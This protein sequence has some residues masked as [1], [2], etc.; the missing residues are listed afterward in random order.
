MYTKT[1]QT[2]DTYI[3][4]TAHELSKQHRVKVA[5]SDGLEQIIILGAGALRMTA[6]ELYED[7]KSVEEAIRAYI[8]SLDK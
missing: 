5:T 3:E 8:D 1:A 4:K 2:A 6:N 7:V